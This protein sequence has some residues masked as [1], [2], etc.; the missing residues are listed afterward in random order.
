MNQVRPRLSSLNHF[1]LL[2]FVLC[3]TAPSCLRLKPSA[4]A[5]TASCPNLASM[6]FHYGRRF[7]FTGA[8]V[9]FNFYYL[10]PRVRQ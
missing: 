8:C 10:P 2:L 4:A 9:C 6:D 3:S 1:N 7:V 5:A